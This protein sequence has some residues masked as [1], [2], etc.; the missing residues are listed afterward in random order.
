METKERRTKVILA[1]FIIILSIF[2]I[3]ATAQAATVYSISNGISEATLSYGHY[4]G[5]LDGTT[6]GYA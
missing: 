2:A 6:S 5:E 3:S 4:G 1:L